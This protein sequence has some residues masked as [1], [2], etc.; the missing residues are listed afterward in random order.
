VSR[1]RDG[2]VGAIAGE[3]GSGMDS[4]RGLI[5]WGAFVC[6]VAWVDESWKKAV[7]KGIQVQYGT[8][9]H[10]MAQD[11]ST[12]ENSSTSAVQE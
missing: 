10:R 6:T 9:W 8:G 11:G 2:A 4:G 12:L 7:T 5:A 1:S 3:A